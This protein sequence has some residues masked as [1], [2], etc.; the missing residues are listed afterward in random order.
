MRR[1][2]GRALRRGQ[3]GARVGSG[4][5]AS[6]VVAASLVWAPAAEA[7]TVRGFGLRFSTNTTGDIVLTGNAATTCPAS[8]SACTSARQATGPAANRVNNSYDMVSVDVD[9]TASTFNSSSADL[10]L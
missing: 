9:S 2:M 1:L 10:A 7:A 3:A 4:A 6:T 5:V 8:S